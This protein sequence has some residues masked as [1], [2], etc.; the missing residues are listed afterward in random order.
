MRRRW[1]ERGY[2]DIGLG[3]GFERG[4]T[5][6]GVARAIRDLKIGLVLLDLVEELWG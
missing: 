2:T 3:L 6:I 1:F 5:D 4:Y